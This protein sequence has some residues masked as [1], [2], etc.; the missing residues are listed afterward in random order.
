MLN[1]KFAESQELHN[2][3]EYVWHDSICVKFKEVLHMF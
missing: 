1:F 3:E 2:S